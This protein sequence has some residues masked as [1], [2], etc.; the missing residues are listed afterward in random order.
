MPT[1][2]HTPH[3]G[4]HCS[5]SAPHDAPGALA[6]AEA[7]ARAAR[8]WADLVRTPEPRAAETPDANTPRG[9]ACCTSEAS[10]AEQAA[11]AARQRARR[12]E[13]EL[14]R[15]STGLVAAAWEAR[16]PDAGVT[17]PP[18]VLT[19]DA[20]ELAHGTVI[21]SW[22]TSRYT[23][24]RAYVCLDCGWVGELIPLYA[25]RREPDAAAAAAHT[26]PQDHA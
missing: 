8:A 17:A 22:C 7:G 4:G 1:P 24:R 14:Y 19:S 26:C 3:P 11:A 20:R 10:P 21:S 5:N 15:Y 2:H 13:V 6:A 25:G 9:S 18:L 12:I 23:G 16:E